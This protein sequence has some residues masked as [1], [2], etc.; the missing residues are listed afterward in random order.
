M[1]TFMCMSVYLCILI[2][3]HVYICM[4][5]CMYELSMNTHTSMYVCLHTLKYS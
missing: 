4:Y 3:I 2:G 1:H 5:T